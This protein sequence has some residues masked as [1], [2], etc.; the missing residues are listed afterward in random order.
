MSAGD[1]LHFTCGIVKIYLLLGLMKIN[2]FTFT[3]SFNFP[4]IKI[5]NRIFS[6]IDFHIGELI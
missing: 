6:K 4:I 2:N 5:Y 3:S 1:F